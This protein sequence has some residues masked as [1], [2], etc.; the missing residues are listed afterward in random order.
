MLHTQTNT[1]DVN[2]LANWMLLIYTHKIDTKETTETASPASFFDIYLKFDIN[3]HP[4]NKLYDQ[5]DDLKVIKYFIPHLGSNITI[6]P[7]IGV[8]ISQLI[9]ACS[10]YSNFTYYI[11]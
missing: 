3:G 2:N 9:R 4:A 11:F 6:A 8:Y 10:L 1:N 7:E 5:R